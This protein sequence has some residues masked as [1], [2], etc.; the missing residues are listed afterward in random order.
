M[1]VLGV[2]GQ[3]R[4]AQR[5]QL[6]DQLGVPVPHRRQLLRGQSE[7][8]AQPVHERVQLPPLLLGPVRVQ[9]VPVDRHHRLRLRRKQQVS[10]RGR[11]G[12]AQVPGCCTARG[13]RTGLLDDLVHYVIQALD[14]GQWVSGAP[15]EHPQERDLGGIVRH[16]VRCGQ[17]LVLWV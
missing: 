8:V 4:G 5:G 17:A 16:I 14:V 10:I 11:R 12:S 2:R 6:P 9:R 3:P 7:V 13:P 15:A 1:G